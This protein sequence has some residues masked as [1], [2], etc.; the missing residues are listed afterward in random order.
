MANSINS[1]STLTPKQCVKSGAAITPG[2]KSI[3]SMK[4]SDQRRVVNNFKSSYYEV[5]ESETVIPSKKLRQWDKKP[6]INE[7]KLFNDQD[8]D[9]I[10]EDTFNSMPCRVPD[11][12]Y[13]WAIT[14]RLRLANPKRN[15]QEVG[16]EETNMSRASNQLD[17]MIIQDCKNSNGQI[18]ILQETP[19][20]TCSIPS[21]FQID[22]IST[23][24]KI[25]LKEAD[26]ISKIYR[27]LNLGFKEVKR[28]NMA[29]KNRGIQKKPWEIIVNKEGMTLLKLAQEIKALELEPQEN[30]EWADIDMGSCSLRVMDDEAV[31]YDM[32]FKSSDYDTYREEQWEQSN[33]VK[34]FTFWNNSVIP[35]A[36]HLEGKK[37]RK[38][39]ELLN[40]LED[41]NFY[42]SI[43]DKEIKEHTT[44]VNK[45][46]SPAQK[47]K[48]E[49]ALHFVSQMKEYFEWQANFNKEC[50]GRV[51]RALS[52]EGK[53]FE[54]VTE[55]NQ[56]SRT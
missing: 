50:T 10:F 5:P 54:D 46:C 21:Q 30:P 15:S 44:W 34:E 40:Q 3:A 45:K 23:F 7:Y 6:F 47:K 31:N 4:P 53:V 27:I 49:S 29:I 55:H 25:T 11:G 37:A 38:F 32:E 26:I 12:K 8:P 28:I 39:S 33:P 17:R 51:V 52:G 1:K 43:S 42:S 16:E 13:D 35:A 2:K 24:A 19:V 48:W 20:G 14:K 22:K 18:R 36:R 9:M 56:H 41:Y